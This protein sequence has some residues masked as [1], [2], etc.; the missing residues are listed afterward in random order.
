MLGRIYTI[1][2][3]LTI[4]VSLWYQRIYLNKSAV[5]FQ[6]QLMAENAVL[7]TITG[8]HYN[9][10]SFEN[11]IL[12]SSFSGENMVYFSNKH[13]EATNNLVYNEVDSSNKNTPQLSIN[14]GNIVIK[15]SKATGE[16]M[17]SQQDS[18]QALMTKNTLKYAILANEVDFNF[19]NNI[20]K[21]SNVYID[22]IKKTLDTEKPI[23]S[24][25]PSGNIKGV[26]FFY[27]M[28]G[29]EFIIKSDV[30]GSIIPT[31]I[32]KN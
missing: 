27:A 9:S 28:N 21:T 20:G 4:L 7:P 26:G 17:S 3:I 13:F 15:T 12:K 19:N 14:D 8:N 29:G 24:H 11:G 16:V 5:E 18:A 2:F 30:E 22:A 10:L 25:G 6:D 1:I 32:P 31:Q 23:K